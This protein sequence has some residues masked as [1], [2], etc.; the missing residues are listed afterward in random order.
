MLPSLVRAG[1]RQAGSHTETWNGL[2]SGGARVPAG[3][4][5]CEVVARTEEGQSARAAASVRLGR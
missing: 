2:G 1:E 3:T 5:L 4:Y